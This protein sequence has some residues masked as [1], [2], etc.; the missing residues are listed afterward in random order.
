VG[1]F[2]SAAGDVEKAVALGMDPPQ[3]AGDL[4]GFLGVVF[5]AGID[6]I[7]QVCRVAEHV[8]VEVR[9]QPLS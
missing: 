5:E 3:E 9:R 6:E 1:V 7:V 2:A 8:G 4:P